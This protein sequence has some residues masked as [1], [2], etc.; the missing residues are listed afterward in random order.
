[1]VREVGKL[2]GWIQEYSSKIN[3]ISHL[4][5]RIILGLDAIRESIFNLGLPRNDNRY[6]LCFHHPTYCYEKR[7]SSIFLTSVS[8]N[9]DCERAVHHVPTRMGDWNFRI[10][11]NGYPDR[12]LCGLRGASV[13]RLHALSMLWT[14]RQDVASFKRDGSE[15]P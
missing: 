1:M 3:E 8:R 10:H 13:S 9:C 4:D 7:H 11:F 2:H 14:I 12:I 15:H 5:R 6:C